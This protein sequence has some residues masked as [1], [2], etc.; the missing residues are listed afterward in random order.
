M[1]S[2]QSLPMWE[3][4]LS[5]MVLLVGLMSACGGRPKDLAA[6]TAQDLASPTLL[7]MEV[8]NEVEASGTQMEDA[9]V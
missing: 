1:K 9:Y 7:N 5:G 2:R 8:L 6:I 4:T 3:R